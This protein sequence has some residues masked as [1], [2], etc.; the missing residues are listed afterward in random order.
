MIWMMVMIK[1]IKTM[2]DNLL[3]FSKND[4][5]E[6]QDGGDILEDEDDQE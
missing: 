1:T 5:D 3:C 6:Q 2:L 4:S